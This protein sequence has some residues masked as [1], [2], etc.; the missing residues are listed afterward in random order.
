MNI[1]SGKI[2]D[3]SSQVLNER[4]DIGALIHA[5]TNSWVFRCNDNSKK[6][7][8]KLVVKIFE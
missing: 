4:Y 7:S 1:P 5:G 6:H 2:I 3:I 8:K